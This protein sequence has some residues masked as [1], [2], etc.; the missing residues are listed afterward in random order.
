VRGRRSRPGLLR[1]HLTALRA[2]ASICGAKV[3]G[4]E[5]GSSRFELVPGSPKHGVHR[6]AIGTAGSASLVLQ[7]IVTGLLHTE[8]ESTIE[9]EGG[10]DNSAAPPSDFLVHVWAPLVRA[11]GVDLHVEIVRRGYY[12]AGGGRIVTSLRVPRALRGFERL[13][14][15]ET[16]ERLAIARVSA[17]AASIGHRELGLLKSALGLGRDELRLEEEPE[18]RGPGNTLSLRWRCAQTTEVF[19]A[20]GE[21]EKS[22]A[23]VAAEVIAEASR[24]MASDVAI[25][26]HQADQLVLLLALAGEGAFTTLTPSLHTRTQLELIPRFL[27]VRI[28]LDESAERATIRITRAER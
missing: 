13:V 27:P 21:K 15:G 11:L 17:L 9:I 10:T 6:F 1:Q 23:D 26:E 25:G 20:F 24:W 4:A 14:R 16:T 22:G 12:P 18:P 3:S 19:T 8:G 7:T 5:L 2:I 28:A